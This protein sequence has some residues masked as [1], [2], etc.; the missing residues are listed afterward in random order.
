LD[1]FQ[2]MT[3]GALPAAEANYFAAGAATRARDHRQFKFL[4]SNARFQS[5]KG[6]FNA[7][8]EGADTLS[9]L[10]REFIRLAQIFKSRLVVELEFNQRVKER[11]LIED[12]LGNYLEELREQ[13]R[14][15]DQAKAEL[16]EGQRVLREELA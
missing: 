13:K 8:I 3:D 6:F 4:A 14:L 16:A 11:G 12:R 10:Q 9:P 2:A 15:E 5:L 7:Q 1:E